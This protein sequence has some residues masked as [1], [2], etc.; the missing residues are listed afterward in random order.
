MLKGL[1][2]PVTVGKVSLGVGKDIDINQLHK[3]FN[4]HHLVIILSP[5]EALT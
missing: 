5:I 1:V 2:V 4:H 3:L